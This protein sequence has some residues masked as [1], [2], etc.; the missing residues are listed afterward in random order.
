MSTTV[1]LR[2]VLL[3]E[4]CLI[5]RTRVS[6]LLSAKSLHAIRS[7]AMNFNCTVLYG[8]VLLAAVRTF[9]HTECLNDPDFRFVDF[10]CGSITHRSLSHLLGTKFT[11]RTRKHF[12]CC[13][14]SAAM[15]TCSTL[16]IAARLCNVVVSSFSRAS[17]RTKG[18]RL[19]L[20]H[21][22]SPSRLD[23]PTQGANS[24][25]ACENAKTFRMYRNNDMQ[26]IGHHLIFALI[27]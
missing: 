13:I 1:D 8:T 12:A 2:T 9:V 23:V 26:C 24:N 14:D 27:C 19:H 5:L 4:S 11:K 16:T 6:F 18:N 7:Y 15:S 21:T 20:T 25:F 3:T 17:N 22:A 10:P